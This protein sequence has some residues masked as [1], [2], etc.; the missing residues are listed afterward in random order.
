MMVL[1]HVFWR[2]PGS[3]VIPRAHP[4]FLDSLVSVRGRGGTR[5]FECGDRKWFMGGVGV[6]GHTD[7]ILGDL[8]A[9]FGLFQH[10]N[11]WTILILI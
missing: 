3:N 1:K 6:W 7:L 8:R 5:C 2:G 11:V 4:S 9:Y 10:E